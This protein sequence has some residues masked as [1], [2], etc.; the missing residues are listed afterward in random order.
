MLA[1]DDL[2]VPRKTQPSGADRVTVNPRRDPRGVEARR[3][4]GRR[5]PGPED[6]IVPLP[7]D[8]AERR[9]SRTG[10]PYRGA[11]HSS[12][13]WAEEDLPALGW[14]HRRH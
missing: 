6:L 13:R 1:P 2:T 9:R 5:P 3:P 7:P 4:R 14:R 11:D 10:E 8:A 12:K